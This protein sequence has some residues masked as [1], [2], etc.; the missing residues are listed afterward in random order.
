MYFGQ[1]DVRVL[2]AVTLDQ[3]DADRRRFFRGR[4]STMK[5]G[6]ENVMVW[7]CFIT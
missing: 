1:M 5:H 3:L 4:T 7:G 6:G 2:S